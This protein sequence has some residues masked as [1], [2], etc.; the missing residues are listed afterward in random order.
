MLSNLSSGV[1]P[2]AALECGLKTILAERDA[3]LHQKVAAIVRRPKFAVFEK[4]RKTV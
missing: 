1:F 4:M 2:F 3:F